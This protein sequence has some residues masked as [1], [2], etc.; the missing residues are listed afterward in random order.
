MRDYTSSV[1]KY[2]LYFGDDKLGG[3]AKKT[4][5]DQFKQ[6]LYPEK[7][8]YTW[9]STRESVS[10]LKEWVGMSQQVKYAP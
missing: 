5:I 1:N 8:G 6:N 10:I 4:I 2:P 3:E 9:D 7:I